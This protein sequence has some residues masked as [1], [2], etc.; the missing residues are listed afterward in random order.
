VRAETAASISTERPAR[1]EALRLAAL[2]SVR[3][4]A[5]VYPPSVLLFSVLPRVVLQVAFLS[6]L[7]YYAGGADGRT[8]AFVGATSQMMTMATVVKA[9]DVLLD[10]R[11][12]GTLYRQRLALVPLPATAA[13]RW[14]I[15]TCEGFCMSL[16][17]TAVLAA[18]LGGASLLLGL[19]RALPL[20]ALLALTTSAFGLAVGSFALTQRADL[21]ITNLAA[22]SLL[23]LT[24]AIAPLS[25]F[26][27]FGAH[28]V[29]VLPL[30]NGLLAVRAVVA[31][32]A[33]LGDALLE[34]AVGIAW[35][36]LAAALLT[37]QEQRGRRLGS[38]D[39]F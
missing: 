8:F 29:R 31:G 26:G 11:V 20:F 9:P 15:Y 18:P 19:I 13:A 36:L 37:W 24:G 33:W 14:W 22:Y 34:L 30:T 16:V 6:Y 39:R 3:D 4:Y 35:G 1:L 28:V 23:V 25:A 27:G 7:G 12:M 21:L 10:E 5:V 17:A 38:D 32:R 2:L